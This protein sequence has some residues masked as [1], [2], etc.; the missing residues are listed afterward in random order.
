[1]HKL[2]PQHIEL[3]QSRAAPLPCLTQNNI[4]GA[5]GETQFLH[6]A[7]V[8]ALRA[9]EGKG[10]VAPASF[11]GDYR[12]RLCPIFKVVLYS[13]AAE[14]EPQCYYILVAHYLVSTSLEEAM[15]ALL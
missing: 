1:M 4:Y 7:K 14:F 8:E 5:T 9:V 11:V 10:N 12:H 2:N 6:F 3:R 13:F 15:D